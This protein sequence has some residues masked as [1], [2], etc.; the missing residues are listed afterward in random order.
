VILDDDFATIVDAIRSGRSIF[1]N[2]QK[3]MAFIFAIH[4]RCAMFSDLRC[5]SPRICCCASAPHL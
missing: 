5:Y 4:V 3:A 2:L 1:D